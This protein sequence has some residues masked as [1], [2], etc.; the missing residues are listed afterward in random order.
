PELRDHAGEDDDESAGGPGD[1][2][3]RAAEQRYRDA[4]DDRRVQALFRL[5]ARGDREGHRQRQ[6][7]HADDQAGGDVAWPVARAV[8]PAAARFEQGGP[9]RSAALA[10]TTVRTPDPPVRSVPVCSPTR[11]STVPSAGRTFRTEIVS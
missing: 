6:R 8:E 9:A 11:A 2:H 10:P 4:G 5:H 3:P 7:D 1:P